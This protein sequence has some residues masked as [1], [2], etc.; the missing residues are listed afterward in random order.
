MAVGLT[1][2]AID[3]VWSTRSTGVSLSTLAVQAGTQAAVIGL[4]YVA[5]FALHL[6]R[7]VRCWA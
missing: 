3:L 4:A 1:I 5:N 7:A 2:G 6:V